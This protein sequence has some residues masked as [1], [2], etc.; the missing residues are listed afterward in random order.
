MSS[1]WRDLAALTGRALGS[2]VRI[3]ADTHDAIA[4][5]VDAMLPPVAKPY[6]QA[7][8]LIAGGVYSV[9]EKAHVRAPQAL[10]PLAEASGKRPEETRVGRVLHPVVNGFHGDLIADEYSSLALPMTLRRD[11]RDAQPSDYG[12]ATGDVV[13]FVHGLAEDEGAWSL[14]GRPSY[15]QRLRDQGLTPVFVRYNTGLHI[16]DNGR[17]LSELLESLAAEWPVELH[18]LSLVGHSMGGLVARSA[19]ATGAAWTHLVRAVVTLGTP[20]KGA[21]LEKAVHIIDWSM[22]RVPEAE[23]IGRIL[24]NRSVGVK[25]LRFGSLLEQDWRDQDIDEFL[26]NRA[27]EVPFLPNATYYWVAAALT[28]DPDHP[29]GRLVGDGM[30]RYPSA[31]AVA[32][33]GVRLGAVSH[34]GLLNDDAVFAAMRAW[35][36]PA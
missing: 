12:D 36:A 13:V 27:A 19:C 22:R 33:E 25:D 16:S 32:G 9:V 30:V 14:R 23:P 24:A 8:R 1:Q 10:S 4:N 31:S 18:S 34:L 26:T 15:G 11:G 29:F 17:A 35:L 2:V 21:P 6:N 5:R 28:R 7:H 3:S 20:H